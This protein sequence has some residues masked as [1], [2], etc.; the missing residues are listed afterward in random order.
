M[1]AFERRKGAVGERDAVHY[2]RGCTG[3][4]VERNARNGVED[5]ADL[6][7]DGMVFEV[8]RR[9]RL[10]FHEFLRQA[11]RAVQKNGK[12]VPEPT[13]MGVLSREDQGQWVLSIPLWQCWTLWHMMKEAYEANQARQQVEYAKQIST[14]TIPN[15]PAL[16]DGV[17]Q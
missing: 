4:I 3:L 11:G 15:L 6:V 16:P 1:G 7:G 17:Q 9:K 13:L 2:L 14:S 12:V 5:A 8:K 10:A